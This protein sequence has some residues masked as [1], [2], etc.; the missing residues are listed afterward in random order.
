[1]IMMSL[2]CL[3]DAIA[4][5]LC[6]QQHAPR[7]L[8]EPHLPSQSSRPG[9]ALTS[10]ASRSWSLTHNS[11]LCLS[12]RIRAAKTCKSHQKP[13]GQID[14]RSFS[15]TLSIF[16]KPFA[17]SWCFQSIYV[18]VLLFCWRTWSIMEPFVFW[19]WGMTYDSMCGVQGPYALRFFE[20]ELGA[21]VGTCKNATPLPDFGGP[22]S[23][24]HGHADPNLT[25]AVELVKE[26]G[27][28]KDRWPSVTVLKTWRFFGTVCVTIS[29]WHF[30]I[31]WK[32]VD[33]ETFFDSTGGQQGGHRQAH[34][35]LR[36]SG[37]WGRGSQHDLWRAVLR[38]TQRLFGHD[39]GQ[40]TSDPT[41]AWRTKWVGNSKIAVENGHGALYTFFLFFSDGFCKMFGNYSTCS[42]RHKVMAPAR[43]LWSTRRESRFKNG[44]KGCARSMPTSAALDLVAKKILGIR[45][46]FWYVFVCAL[47][48]SFFFDFQRRP[49]RYCEVQERHSM[50]WSPNW[51]EILRKFD[52][53]WNQL[54]PRQG[55]LS[56]GSRHHIP[57]CCWPPNEVWWHRLQANVHK[58]YS[59]ISKLD[60]IG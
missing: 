40:C 18:K 30:D 55:A 58:I 17:Q 60:K 52:G 35:Q 23:A 37:G 59:I 53:Q 54:L 6:E 42:T 24:W 22:T 9:I 39:R 50:L 45:E 29:V 41:V 36:R 56:W 3:M 20:T 1:M 2:R 27:L 32:P 12:D 33:F 14:D 28:N 10:R 16:R 57:P 51:L 48:G 13:I 46:L 19:C 4:E 43:P 47:G 25:Y 8:G 44:L 21:P 38:V 26:M 49:G 11:V 34:P 15:F 5:G 7:R 31:F